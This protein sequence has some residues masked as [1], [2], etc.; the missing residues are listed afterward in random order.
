MQSTAG[1]LERDVESLGEC[2]C[3]CAN[4]LV[5]KRYSFQCSSATYY[6]VER[7]CVLNLEDRKQRPDAFM[8]QEVSTENVT[9]LGLICSQG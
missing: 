6:P 8:K 5:S 3:H 2:Q 1:G 4:S 7:D 9:Y